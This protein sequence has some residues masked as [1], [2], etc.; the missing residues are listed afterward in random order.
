MPPPMFIYVQ[1][2]DVANMEENVIPTK[3]FLSTVAKNGK[4]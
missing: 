2:H 4:P 3:I 1:N